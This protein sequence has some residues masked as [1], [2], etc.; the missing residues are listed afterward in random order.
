MKIKDKYQ[1]KEQQYLNKVKTVFERKYGRELSEDEVQQIG[2]S[3]RNFA[4]ISLNV[5][6]KVYTKTKLANALIAV[7][8][9]LESE[10]D[11]NS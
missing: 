10:R 11:S 7:K 6:R 8:D 1:N 5:H 4:Q 3:L 9:K 2:D